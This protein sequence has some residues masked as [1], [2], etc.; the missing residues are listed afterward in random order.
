MGWGGG[1]PKIACELCG[2]D[3]ILDMCCMEV[4]RDVI[5][6]HGLGMEFWN[7][8]KAVGGGML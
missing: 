7:N 3:G 5:V 8:T 1:W 6:S 4:A 2:G